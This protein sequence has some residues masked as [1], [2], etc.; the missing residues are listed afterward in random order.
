MRRTGCRGAVKQLAGAGCMIWLQR[1]A[2]SQLQRKG[3][4]SVVASRGRRGAGLGATSRGHRG[5]QNRAATSKGCRI[6]AE[7]GCA[8]LRDQCSK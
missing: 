5:V 2:Q 6:G 3:A 1:R 4:E 7:Q 8:E